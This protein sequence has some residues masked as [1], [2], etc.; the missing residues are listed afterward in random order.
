MEVDEAMSS[1]GIVPEDRKE[2][3]KSNAGIYDN[4][5]VA[6]SPVQETPVATRGNEPREAEHEST[7]REYVL[8]PKCGEKIWL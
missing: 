1:Y 2:E 4:A 6:T 3:I 8:C 7:R 5:P